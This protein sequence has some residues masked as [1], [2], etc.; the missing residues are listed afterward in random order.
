VKIPPLYSGSADE[1]CY[2]TKDS[3]CDSISVDMI[4]DNFETYMEE[5]REIVSH[6]FTVGGTPWYIKVVPN[7]EN[8]KNKEQIGVFLVNDDDVYHTVGC[9][10]RIGETVFE[11]RSKEIG[12][13]LD[14]GCPTF[15]THQQCKEA[16]KDGRLEIKVEV[17]VLDR[18][19][20]IIHGRGK[21]DSDMN[22]EIME[23]NLKI[24]EAKSF[25]DFCIL[26]NGKSFPCHKAF[27]SARSSVFKSMIEGNMKEATEASVNLDK[28][29]TDVIE[30][31]VKFFYTNQLK[32]AELE[33]NAV[34]FLELGE[35]YDI[36]SLKA[37]AE[38]FMIAN[39]D[40]V[41]MLSFFLAGDLFHGEKIREA[42]KMFIRQNKRSLLE[43]EGWKEKLEGRTDLVFEL[44]ES[45]L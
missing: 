34:S 40:T 11:F 14:W 35:K 37:I 8:K 4:I 18:D 26:S 6:T 5:T 13:A 42:A 29:A 10:L 17:K 15:M 45:L 28:Y 22:T 31:F 38:E 19:D 30:G 24:F 36:S 44:L 25:T 23:V 20:H 9:K 16:L 39:L 43:Q 3:S 7:S 41:N 21:M 32:D 2:V 12:D 27:L 1:W 33:E